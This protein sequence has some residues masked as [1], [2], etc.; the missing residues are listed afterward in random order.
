MRK[1]LPLLLVA[2]GVRRLLV[3]QPAAVRTGPHRHRHHQ[4]GHR[5]PADCRPDRRL[6]VKEGDLVTKGQLLAVLAPDEL[7]AGPRLLRPDRRGRQLAGRGKRSGAAVPGAADRRSDPRR[8]RRRW[9]RPSRS[10][11]AAEAELENARSSYERAAEDVHAGHRA[12]E[13]FDQAR[14]AYDVAKSRLASLE[15]RSTRSV[16]AVALA[17]SNAEQ[18]AVRRSQ[19]AGQRAAA[20]GGRGAAAKA[21]VRLAYT[22]LHAPIDGIVDVRAARQARSS[23]PGSRS[24][25]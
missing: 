4:R 24:S 6:L 15:N 10:E 9:R 14:T 21:D 1:L 13:Q 3:R 23:T 2:A 25:R 20:G 7:R 18:I 17:R 11:T 22:E 19:L 5:Q 12:A 16:R 8:P